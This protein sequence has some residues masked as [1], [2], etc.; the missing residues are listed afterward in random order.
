MYVCMY[1]VRVET[2]SGEISNLR[3]DKGWS[4]AFNGTQRENPR[5][6]IRWSGQ[7]RPVASSIGV[8]SASG[9]FTIS[10]NSLS[11]NGAIFEQQ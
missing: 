2:I 4:I 8:E 10:A 7:I 6:S 5:R 9:T 1:V 11:C 3:I